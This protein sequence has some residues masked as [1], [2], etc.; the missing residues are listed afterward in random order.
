MA[1]FQPTP[2]DSDGADQ[3]PERLC[4]EITPDGQ[5]R[6]YEDEDDETD[7][8]DE[9][10]EPE[11]GDND[12]IDQTV[13]SPDQVLQLVKHWL[14]LEAAEPPDQQAPPAVAPAAPQQNPN[15][16]M[17]AAWNA[18]AAKRGPTGFRQ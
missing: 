9:G 11:A 10:Q 18:E 16:A 8:G 14:S 3:T 15:T 12:D 6:V 17:K 1:D 4:I 5:F 13:Q 7:D 2:A